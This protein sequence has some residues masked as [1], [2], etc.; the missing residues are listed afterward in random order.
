MNGGKSLIRVPAEMAGESLSA[1]R[2]CDDDDEQAAAFST[3]ST[4]TE[5]RTLVV[6]AVA[7]AL[8]V[9][10]PLEVPVVVVARR[11]HILMATK[12]LPKATVSLRLEVVNVVDDAV[13]SSAVS[14]LCVPLLLLLYM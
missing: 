6:E 4:S 11:S 14:A 5:T 1:L 12:L 9:V 7:T 8:V 13:S 2:E 3:H 10:V